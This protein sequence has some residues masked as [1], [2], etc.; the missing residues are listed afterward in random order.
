MVF[1]LLGD[2]ILGELVVQRQI[3][4]MGLESASRAGVEAGGGEGALV[5]RLVASQPLHV[6]GVTAFRECRSCPDIVNALDLV[7]PSVAIVL[8]EDIACCGS[9]RKVS[10]TYGTP[11]RTLA[12]SL[13][14]HRC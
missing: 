1:R 5:P 13:T 11:R 10:I 14:P 7:A 12:V 2:V 3:G 4:Q 8:I 6:V 9:G